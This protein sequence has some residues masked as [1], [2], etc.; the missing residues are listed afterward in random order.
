MCVYVLYLLKDWP[1]A[2]TEKRKDCNSSGFLLTRMRSQTHRRLIGFEK[3]F[4]IG[5]LLFYNKLFCCCQQPATPLLSA[6]L[7]F[8][9]KMSYSYLS[10]L[11]NMDSKMV[12]CLKEQFKI[13]GIY[14]YSLCYSVVE[15]DEKI[16]AN[17]VCTLYMKLEPACDQLSLA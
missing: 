1:E 8:I 4:Y 3:T 15:L 10:I 17:Y 11:I 16:D 13:L 5:T 6:H 9:I 14:S 12:L 2:Q 7:N